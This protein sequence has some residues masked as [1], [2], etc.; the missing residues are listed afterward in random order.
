MKL[1]MHRVTENIPNCRIVCKV[2][3]SVMSIT[4]SASVASDVNVGSMGLPGVTFTTIVFIFLL[5]NGPLS[6]TTSV[7]EVP[8]MIKIFASGLA[9]VG[10]S[11][12]HLSSPLFR[13]VAESSGPLASD[14]ARSNIASMKDSV[15]LITEAVSAV[16]SLDPTTVSCSWSSC[17]KLFI[18]L[19]TDSRFLTVLKACSWISTQ[20]ATGVAATS[21]DSPSGNIEQWHTHT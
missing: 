6:P 16:V 5:N 8:M 15:P 11:E 13:K 9:T 3:R 10:G 12:K 4:C 19:T 1:K 20:A 2:G 18:I 14:G 21:D 17:R 7:S